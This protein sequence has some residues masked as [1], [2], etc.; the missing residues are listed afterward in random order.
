MINMSDYTA[1][2]HREL[3]EASEAGDC[4]RVS[5]LEAGADP[6]IYENDHDVSSLHRTAV[7]EDSG[8]AEVA[9]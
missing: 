6:F 2:I 5:E 9:R 1:D 3:Y 7:N 4:A 8:E